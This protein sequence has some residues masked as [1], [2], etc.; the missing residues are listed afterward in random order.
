MPRPSR[1]P[2]ATPTATPLLRRASAGLLDAA[3]KPSTIAKARSARVMVLL[4]GQFQFLPA[5]C[6][7]SSEP[8]DQFIGLRP[9]LPV[10]AAPLP[11]VPRGPEVPGTIGVGIAVAWRAAADGIGMHHVDVARPDLVHV[12]DVP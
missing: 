5:A 3:P 2:A 11:I 8:V 9:P 6:P 7:E 4:I 12:V 1:V 10:P